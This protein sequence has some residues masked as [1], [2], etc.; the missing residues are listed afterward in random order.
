MFC[1]RHELNVILIQTLHLV[2]MY[3]VSFV[4]SN[5]QY[6]L[7]QLQPVRDQLL[8]H[9]YRSCHKWSVQLYYSWLGQ[10][11]TLI[12]VPCLHLCRN[13]TLVLPELDA[14]ARIFKDSDL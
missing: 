4:Q 5:M 14:E 11:C 10:V 3:N 13:T 9:V 6:A 8:V 12:F 2:P 7:Y 1:I